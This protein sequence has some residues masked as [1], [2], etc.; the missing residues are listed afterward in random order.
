[1]TMGK[2]ITLIIVFSISGVFLLL[3]ISSFLERGFLLNNAYLYASKEKRKSMD[4][5]P[6]YKQSA[7]VFW[8]LSAVF[9][10]IGLGLLFQNEM[11]FLVEIPLL[12]GVTTYAYV[13]TAQI[14]KQSKK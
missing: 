9:I 12:T 14:N 8:F 4:R 7:V 2:L 13:S 11:F 10:V 3:G 5:K 1:M 6:Y